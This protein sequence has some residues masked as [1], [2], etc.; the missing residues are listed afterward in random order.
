MVNPPTQPWRRPGALLTLVLG[1]MI[2]AQVVWLAVEGRPVDWDAAWYL[3]VAV[4]LRRT[5]QEEGWTA[6]LSAV[7]SAFGF[8]APGFSMA[9]AVFMAFAGESPIRA[10]AVSLVSWLVAGA[11]LC[12]LARRFLSPNAAALAA[13]LACAMPLSFSMARAAMVEASLTA[14]VVAFIYHSAASERLRRPGHVAAL[15]AWGAAGLMLKITFPVYVLAPALLLTLAPLRESRQQFGR[16]ALTWV[17]VAAAAVGVAGWLWYADNWQ[18]SLGF[19]RSAGYGSFASIYAVPVATWLLAAALHAVSPWTVVTLGALTVAVMRRRAEGTN[20]RAVLV[21]AAW[22]APPVLLFLSSSLRYVRFLTA[23]LPAVA[24]A[25]AALADPW[26][27]RSTRSAIITGAL[28]AGPPLA[29]FFVA[30]IPTPVTEVVR[31][32]VEAPWLG[33]NVNWY[34]GPPDQ[35]PWPNVEI[36]AAAGRSAGSGAPAVLR[37]NVDL[38]EL[39]HNNLKLEALLQRA[40]VVPAQIDQGSPEG[41]LSSAFDGDLLLIQVGG[42]VAAD[43]LNVQRGVVARE[44]ASGRHPYREIGR[45]DLPGGRQVALLERRCV[46]VE[47]GAAERPLA[48][49]GRGLDLL[50]LDLARSAD[51]LVS[52]R[53]RYRARDGSHPL[54]AA[55]IELTDGAGRVLGAGEH[56]LCRRPQG[57][58]PAGAVVE[59]TFFLPAWAAVPGAGLRLGLRDLLTGAPLLVESVGPGL[60]VVAGR[61]EFARVGDR[62]TSQA[63]P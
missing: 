61:V 12:F 22:A 17:G 6:V 31:A 5:F 32:W 59:D 11:Y 23:V 48:M 37:L 21:A 28:L 41:A 13:L 39:N 25:V 26:L 14:G 58:W 62:L 35:R 49:L 30:T 53:T 63:A 15:S 10:V 45:F 47:V 24:L 36:V 29:Y 51:G 1:A 16:I 18:T 7:R 38:P 3:E 34:E 40:A 8:K 4:S 46:V 42:P 20:S 33:G 55:S 54:L 60:G 57:P 43:F 19:A 9:A 44:A 27:R 56:L 50:A 52:V 2:A